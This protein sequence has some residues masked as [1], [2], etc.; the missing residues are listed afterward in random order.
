M[1]KRPS[2]RLAQGADHLYIESAFLDEDHAAAHAKKHLT[3]G[4][5]GELYPPPVENEG[6]TLGMFDQAYLEKA[7]YQVSVA[8]DG[9]TALHVIRHDRPD[10]V[11]LDLSL[12]GRGGLDV[13]RIVRDDSSLAA[14]P[15]SPPWQTTQ[16][17]S[18]MG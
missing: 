2:S 11:L 14:M 18:H 1:T 8:Y 17:L 13:T 4:Q 6:E 7:G 15:D 3:A 9:E 10:L 16:C 5:A 12:P